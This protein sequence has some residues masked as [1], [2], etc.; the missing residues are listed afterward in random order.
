VY[1]RY[2]IVNDGDLKEAAG[3]LAGTFSGTGKGSSVTLAG[4]EAAKSGS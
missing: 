2:A 4:Q 1:R 3:K